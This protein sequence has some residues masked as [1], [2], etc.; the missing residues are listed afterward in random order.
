MSSACPIH[1]L[2]AFLSECPKRCLLPC[3]Q[4]VDFDG[5]SLR[6]ILPAIVKTLHGALSAGGRVITFAIG[7]MVEAFT[8]S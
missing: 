7:E 3:A 5:E 4:I 1:S 6:R 2:C 8:M